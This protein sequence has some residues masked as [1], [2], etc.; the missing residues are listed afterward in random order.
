[1]KKQ[2]SLTITSLFIFTLLFKCYDKAVDGFYP[3]RI[4]YPIHLQT[5]P[6]YFYSEKDLTSA[7]NAL[8]Q[9][10]YYL[11]SGSQSFVFISKDKQFI[12]KF[13]KHYRWKE[14]FYASFFPFFKESNQKKADGWRATYQ[15]CMFCLKEFKEE[16]ALL[17]MQLEPSKNIKNS[18]TVYNR[19]GKKYTLSLSN[20]SFA[21]QKYAKPTSE[22]L[23]NLKKAG[24][25]EIAKEH[26][27]ALFD[28][29]LQK[30]TKGFT[31]KDP[32]FLNNFGFVDNKAVSFDI[33]GLIKDPKKDSIYFCN[34]E[35]KKVTKT[36]L[37]WLEK[38]YPELLPYTQELLK[39]IKSQFKV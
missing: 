22:D 10:F 27:K 33:G 16:T 25:L 35:L 34:H 18:I 3:Y 23:L 36:L 26:M 38:H 11:A 32:N 2:L 37:P 1:M 17:Y 28:T 15:S 14:P 12:L 5:S 7:T 9:P 19:L 20:M 29:M 21:L 31:D 8:N 24:E 6:S 39:D 30:R 4:K 13:F